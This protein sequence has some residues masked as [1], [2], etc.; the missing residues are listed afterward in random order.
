MNLV[1]EP[2]VGKKA[3]MNRSW[4]IV[5]FKTSA[6]KLSFK[7]NYLGWFQ[8]GYGKEVVADG[9]EPIAKEVPPTQFIRNNGTGHMPVGECILHSNKYEKKHLRQQ[10]IGQ[11]VAVPKIIPPRYRQQG[12]GQDVVP[13]IIPPRY[14]GGLAASSSRTTSSTTTTATT[15]GVPRSTMWCNDQWCNDQ[16]HDEQYDDDDDDEQYDNDCYNDHGVPRSTVYRPSK[17]ASLV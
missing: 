14:P 12:I 13:K 10:G 4:A 15:H 3:N 11:D 16:W 8:E 2:V 17:A 6:D 7:E 1:E 9:Y 5:H